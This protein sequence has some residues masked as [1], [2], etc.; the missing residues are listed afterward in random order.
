MSKVTD[1]KEDFKRP[2]ELIRTK[3]IYVVRHAEAE[4]NVMEREA[5]G[6]AVARGVHQKSLLEQ[7]RKEVLRENGAALLDAPL[8]KEGNKQARATGKRMSHLLDQ[9]DMYT[10]PEVVLVSPLRRAL[11]TATSCFFGDT[12]GAENSKATP[13]F[14]AMEILREKRTG[15]LCDERRSVVELQKEFPHVDF[16][17]LKRQ[18][19]EEI[20]EGETNEAVRQRVRDFLDHT[21]PHVEGH[22]LA[23]VSHKGWLREMRQVL[24]I[25]EEMDPTRLTIKFDIDDWETTLFGNAELR[26]AKMDWDCKGR[27]CGIESRSLD[28]TIEYISGVDTDG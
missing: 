19:M 23:L 25:R 22:F 16:S 10:P 14:V 7:V 4:H 15:L 11:Q 21:L 28:H 8:S 24:K 13:R 27:L 1:E 3:H 17:D 12:T 26:V 6:G 9:N 5:V 20:Q 2:P 18:D